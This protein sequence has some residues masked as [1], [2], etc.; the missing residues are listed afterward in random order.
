MASVRRVIVRR[1]RSAGPKAAQVNRPA[2]GP[3]LL[4]NNTIKKFNPSMLELGDISAPCREKEA[5]AAV[6]DLTGFTTFC[7]QVD[8]YLAIPRFLNDFLEWFFSNIRQKITQEDLGDRSVLWTGLPVMVKFLGDGLMVLWDARKMSEDQIC[9]LAGV[10][11]TICQA[12]RTDFYPYIS[13]AVNKP[14]SILRCGVARGK[15]FSIGNDKEYVGHCINNASRL[16]RLGSLSF[17]FPHRGF[18][19][20]E[21]MPQ[22]YRQIFVPKYVTLRGIGAN[23]LIWIVRDE[24]NNLPQKNREMFRSIESG[25]S[26]N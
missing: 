22:E 17:C 4:D 2:N 20:Q 3:K 21:Y 1:V 14:P 12:Y 18:Q 8:A 15:I 25:G 5:V 7:N 6:F 23:E 24:Y 26:A 16:S 10:L 19:V 13:R 9:R 11:Y